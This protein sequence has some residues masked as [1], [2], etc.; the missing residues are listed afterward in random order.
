MSRGRDGWRRDAREF[1]AQAAAFD[2][3]AVPNLHSWWRGD[4]GIALG[5]GVSAWTSKVNGYV[6]SQA[7]GADQPLYNTTTTEI[8]DRA[9]V[10]FRT[11]DVLVSTAPAST[12]NFLHNGSGCEVFTMLVPRGA[13]GGGAYPIYTTVDIT[14]STPGVC[15]SFYDSPDQMITWTVNDTTRIINSQPT[16]PFARN[17]GIVHNYSYSESA[18][19]EWAGRLGNVAIESG[20][21]SGAPTNADATYT[22]KVGST[23]SR[24]AA[25][26]VAEIIIYNRTL[27]TAERTAVYD[28]LMSR[29][30]GVFRPESLGSYLWFEADSGITQTAD[31]ISA[32][33]SK[34]SSKTFTQGTGANQPLYI[35]SDAAYNNKPIIQIDDGDR[36]LICNTVSIPFPMSTFEYGEYSATGSWASEFSGAGGTQVL[37]NRSGGVNNVYATN[38][39]SVTG[40]SI[41]DATAKRSLYR[42]MAV[43]TTCTLIRNNGTP[44][45]GTN[46]K[47]PVAAT[48]VVA[49]IGF[50]GSAVVGKQAAYFVFTRELTAAEITNL[51][52]WCVAKYG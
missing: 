50:P 34:T 31:R 49:R 12:W 28:Y 17:T 35:A 38:A 14:V 48:M 11:S 6:L 4:S 2:P 25:M 16:T 44:V 10:G 36:S 47:L 40:P 21:S 26:D 30:L 3:T 51:H 23:P 7:T 39:G 46:A 9:T 18:S 32:Y 42:G 43:D 24:A 13:K 8:S 5:T 15:H 27:T 22:L 29:Y 52:A 1:A 45:T 41:T 19:P 20:A 33:A 37:W